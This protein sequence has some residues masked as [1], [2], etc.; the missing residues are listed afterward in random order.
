VLGDSNSVRTT[1]PNPAPSRI[2]QRREATR[3]E[4]LDAAWAIV[5]EHGLAGLSLRDLAARVGMRAASLYSYFPSKHAIYDAMFRQGYE[6]FVQQMVSDAD[7]GAE[8]PDDV[9]TSALHNAHRFFDFCTSDPVRYQLLFQRTIPGFTPSEQSYALAVEA[10]ERTVGTLR[11]YGLD[12]Q[13]EL[14]LWSAV[15]TGLVD[16]QL[17]NDPGG[18]RWRD[19]VERAVDVLLADVTRRA[20]T[21]SPHDTSETTAFHRTPKRSTR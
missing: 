9:R 19:L 14:D 1:G 7:V 4:I 15:F 11:R 20:S 6:A 16:Q 5:R 8:P 21:M 3:G 18:T 12:D 13:S 2:E 10:Y 17:S